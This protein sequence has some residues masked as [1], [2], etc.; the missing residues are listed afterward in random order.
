MSPVLGPLRDD[1]AP[2]T[3]PTLLR[4]AGPVMASRLGIM[5]MGLVDTVC[6]GRYSATELGYHALGWGPTGIV[7]VVAIGLL[8]G[9]QVVSSQ[10]IGEG[11][12]S[13][14]G[15]VLRRGLVYAFWLGIAA[16]V[17][18]AGAGPWFI[19]HIGLAPG[20]ADGA[21]P[22]LRVFALSL[23]P[24][25]I[26]DSG[27]FWL[28]AHGK[29]SRGMAAMWAA[30]AVN[31]ALNLWL[32]PGHSPFPIAGAVASA[33]AT[34]VSRVALL[35]FVAALILG[36]RDA[37]GFGVLARPAPD[38]AA[39]PRMR[40]VGYANALSHFIEVSAFNGMTL[41]AGWL[42]AT[43][44]A[45]WAIVI[46]FAALVFMIPLGLATATGVLVGRAHGAGDRAGVRRA[47]T[48][49]FGTA[50]ALTLTVCLGVALFSG[51][52]AAGYT[53]D[54]AVRIAAAAALLLSCGFFVGDGLQVIGAQSLRSQ[55]DIWMPT[56]THFVSYTL[57]MIPCAYVFGFVWGGGVPGIVWALIVASVVSAG[58]LGARFAW[59]VRR[60]VAPAPIVR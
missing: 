2:I 40:R 44:V 12:A 42:G 4:L 25:L 35:A 45:T 23:L 38:P 48:L 56:V 11:R 13:E 41:F 58:L 29:P 37:R 54:P 33:W 36:W 20:L 21:A 52:L 16:A 1:H 24:I 49:G 27:I 60:R 3:L 8:G 26:A 18:L 14:T 15:A 55:N 43:A 7:L 10:L 9:V 50:L 51:D 19:H 17:L 5:A 6:V 30:N 34:A 59:V 31:L 39:G 28:E 53:R 57:V 46:N 32:V 47:G 22:V